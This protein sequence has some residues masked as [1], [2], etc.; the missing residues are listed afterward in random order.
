MKTS[1]SS[2]IERTTEIP[3]DAPTRTLEKG[4]FLLGLFDADNPEWALKELEERAGLPKATTR[5]LM[6]TLEASRWVAYDPVSHKFHL[7][8]SVLRALYLATSHPELVRIAHPFL[9]KLAEETTESCSLSVWTDQ[10]PLIIDAVP[11]SRHFKPRTY[12]GMLLEGIISADAQVLI[13]FGP[14]EAWDALLAAPIEPRTERTVTDPKVLRERWRTV[15]REG[16]AFD[17][18]E[19]KLEAPAVAAPV[20]DRLGQLRAAIHVVPPVERAS[21]EEMLRYAF[22]V[23][24]TAAEIFKMLGQP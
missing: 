7:G 3:R 13:A 16:V 22:A 10:G 2:D 5:R 15:K 6:R 9:V 8:S 4:L 14:E 11:T 24:R 18:G 23:R 21:E 20:F 17:R 12:S 1:R 19:W